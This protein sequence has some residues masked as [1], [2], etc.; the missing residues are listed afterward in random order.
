M[1]SYTNFKVGFTVG[2]IMV[3]GIT[4]HF[5]YKLNKDLWNRNGKKNTIFP[6][7]IVY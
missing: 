3:C 4:F 1:K 7:P 2:Y 5:N 6:N